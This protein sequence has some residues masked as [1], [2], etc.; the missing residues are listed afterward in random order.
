MVRG[1][2]SDT[3]SLISTSVM[4]TSLSNT[5]DPSIVYLRKSERVLS[6][7]NKH[8][9]LCL[10]TRERCTHCGEFGQIGFDWLR[11]IGSTTCTRLHHGLAL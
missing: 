2:C 10:F 1:G 9:C 4:I 7:D 8:L 11:C 3:S 6:D 5:S